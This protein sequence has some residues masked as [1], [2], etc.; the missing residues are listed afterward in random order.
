MGDFNC[1]KLKTH[2][3]MA[4]YVSVLYYDATPVG[5]FC[6]HATWA[7]QSNPKDTLYIITRIRIYHKRYA[8]GVGG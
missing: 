5:H 2:D 4:S 8:D 7:R 6:Y 3:L 1:Y